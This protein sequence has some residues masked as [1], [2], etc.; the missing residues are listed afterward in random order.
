M[1]AEGLEQAQG[2]GM[3]SVI[4]PCYDAS[5]H[6]GKAVASVFA[7]NYSETELIVVDDGSTDASVEILQ[8]LAME[9]APRM[10][11]LFQDRL[12]PYAARNLGLAHAKGD[13]VA[14]LDA[15]DYWETDFLE[16]LLAALLDSG[17]DLAYCGWQ[18][19]GEQSADREPYVPPK[20]E[21]GDM[22][23][24]FLEGCP[25][26]IHAA[27]IRRTVVDAVRGFS[28][29]LPT[30][31]DY[32]FWLH[33]LAHTQ[34]MI[35]VPEV[36]AFYRWHGG[37]ISKQKWRQVLNTVQVRK[38]FIH[39]YPGL[40]AQIPSARLKDLTDGTLLREAYRAY[41]KRDLTTAQALFRRAFVHRIW[42][43]GDLK[44]ILPS[45]MPGLLFHL[46]VESV[47]RFREKFV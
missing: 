44:Y 2:P 38:D 34:K 37:Q 29:R 35:L 17:A 23:S 5:A 16:K 41:W 47:D 40:V 9:H 30:S 4:M 28:E 11:L 18:N 26:P 10:T 33:M 3:I 21:D 42:K 39:R 32:D 25:W 45:L 46:L 1:Q 8:A 7:Q 14:F 6:V 13:F 24:A 43:A 31:M 19:L 27:L 22:V 12:G 15:G 20:Y 36:L